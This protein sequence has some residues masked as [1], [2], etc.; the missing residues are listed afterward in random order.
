MSYSALVPLY[1]SEQ[2][3]NYESLLAKLHTMVTSEKHRLKAQV[4]E[5]LLSAL[6]FSVQFLICQ[7]PAV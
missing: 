6:G 1:R 3:Q 4:W 2:K 7:T 5:I